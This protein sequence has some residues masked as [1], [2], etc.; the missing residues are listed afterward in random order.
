MIQVVFITPFPRNKPVTNLTE[1][2]LEVLANEFNKEAE[3]RKLFSIL[4]I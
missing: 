4:L 2:S 1:I 3:K